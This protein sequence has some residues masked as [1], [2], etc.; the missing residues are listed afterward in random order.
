MDSYNQGY[1]VGV[2]HGKTKIGTATIGTD[3][4][5]VFRD[6]N[7]GEGDISAAQSAGFYALAYDIGGDGP[8]GLAGKTVISFRGTDTSLDHSTGWSV[9]AGNI[10]DWTQAPLA[11]EFYTAATGQ[12]YRDGEARDVLLTGHS[13]GGGL[14]GFVS[15]LS[16]TEGVGFDHM[17]F[18]AAALMQVYQDSFLELGESVDLS[19]DVIA[20]KIIDFAYD[21]DSR[22]TLPSPNFRGVSVQNEIL[23]SLRDGSLPMIGVFL[24]DVLGPAIRFADFFGFADNFATQNLVDFLIAA[25]D[26]PDTDLTEFAIASTILTSSLELT[27]NNE[28]RVIPQ[29]VFTGFSEFADRANLVHSAQLMV[30]LEYAHFL[31]GA[32]LEKEK[33]REI[34]EP[35]LMSFFSDDIGKQA[36]F[37][38]FPG[39]AASPTEGEGSSASAMGRAIA[40]SALDGSE[41][42]VFGNTGI[43][44]L[45]DDANELGAVV[46]SGAL[47]DVM[48]AGLAELI[49]QFAGQMALQEVNYLALQENAETDLEPQEGILS[50]IR[51]G[52]QVVKTEGVDDFAGAQ[53]LAVDM[54]RELW[55]VEGRDADRRGDPDRELKFPGV[56]TLITDLFKAL[57]G[58]D[59][60]R[61][62][63]QELERP[64]LDLQELITEWYGDLAEAG[65][66]LDDTPNLLDIIVD[67]FIIPLDADAESLEYD[68]AFLDGVREGDP[69]GRHVSLALNAF[70]ADTLVGSNHE[71]ILFLRDNETASGGLGSDLV[72]GSSSEEGR[73]RILDNIGGSL[74]QGGTPDGEPENYFD[75]VYV[76]VRQKLNWVETF[77]NW[78]QEE[79]EGTVL[80][81]SALEDIADPETLGKH[82]FELLRLETRDLKQN[83]APIIE[84][85][86]RDRNADRVSHDKLIN[87]ERVLLTQ[88]SDRAEI[89]DSWLQAPVVLDFNGF[90][91]GEVTSADY[92]ELSFQELSAGIDMV[93]GAIRSTERGEGAERP[94]SIISDLMPVAW[95]PL[96][97][98]GFNPFAKEEPLKFSGAEKIEGT[99]YA[100]NLILGEVS[101]L[102]T[103]FGGWNDN[104][105]PMRFGEINAG[106]GEDN[107]FVYNPQYVENGDRL[108]PE[109]GAIGDQETTAGA[110][111]Y[112]RIDGGEGNDWIS[113]IGGE[114]AV[115]IGGP[116]RDWIY[117]TSKGGVI[118]GDTYT[119][120]A[121]FL[122]D[123][124]EL[125]EDEVD[126]T[127][128]ENSDKIWYY[129]GTTMMDP[130]ESDYLA[131]RGVPLVGGTAGLPLWFSLSVGGAFAGDLQMIGDGGYNGIYFD[132]FI[133][134][135][136]YSHH[137]EDERLLVTNMFSWAL[138]KFPIF[139]GFPKA[140]EIPGVDGEPM[141]VGAMVFENYDTFAG[142]L[143]GW[144]LNV[145]GDLSMSFKQPNA[146]IFAA[147][148]VLSNVLGTTTV[149]WVASAGL[150][151]LPMLDLLFTTYNTALKM[152]KNARW[153]KH[154]DPLIIDLDGDGIETVSRD[155]SGVF[156]DMDGDFFRE[157]TGWV[158]PDDG[159]LTYDKNGN[160]RID[161]I[162]ELFGNVGL[163]GIEELASYDLNGDGVIDAA[164]AIYAEL[165][166]W[167]DLDQDGETDAGEL[168]SL[169]ERGI[170]SIELTRNELGVTTPQGTILDAYIRVHFQD[171]FVTTA[172]DSVLEL[173]HMLTEFAGESGT[174]AWLRGG[175]T[176]NMRGV[177]NV[178]DLSIAMSNDFELAE[179]VARDAPLM[180]VP[181]LQVLREQ[182]SEALSVWGMVLERSRELTP[183][184]TR[185]DA[186]GTALVDRGV[187]VED[188]TGG[189][190]TLAS[191]ADI[192]DA[193]GAIIARPTLQ[194]VMAQAAGANESWALEQ[195]FSASSRAAP[196]EHREN[197]PY[198]AQIVDGRVVVHDYGVQGADGV[199]SLA[200]G[201]DVLAQDGSVIA[202]PTVADILAQGAAK[203]LEWR[204]EDLQHN[205]LAELDVEAIGVYVIDE[206]AVDY[207][208]QVTDRDGSFHVWARN[209][210]RALELQHKNG[211]A[212]DFNLRN[213]EVDFETLDEVGSSDDSRY[214][215]ELLTPGQFNFAV[216]T[217]VGLEFRP[218]MLTAFVDS[219]T[220]II[221]YSVD[222]SGEISLSQDIYESGIKALLPLVDLM[223]DVWV[224]TSRG[225][226]VRM[227][228]QGGLEEFA[229]DLDF[230][231]D[232]NKFS[233][234]TDRELAPMFEAI[235]EAAPEGYEPALNYLTGW[236]QIMSFVLA[237]YV[238]DG[239]GN[240][241]GAAV[242]VDQKFVMQMLLPA[243]EQVGI[244]MDLRAVLNTFRI[245]ET[246]LIDHDGD[247]TEVTGTNRGD[248]IYLSGGDQLYRG[249]GGA[250]TYFV[251]ADFGNDTIESVGFTADDELRFSYVSSEDVVARREGT[252]LIL[253]A[254]GQDGTLT[255]KDHFLGEANAFVGQK[256]QTKEMSA[257]VFSDGVVWDPFLIAMAV[258]DPR[259]TDDVIVGSPG[260]DVLIG[261][262][263]NDVMIGG[264]GDDIYVYRVG[265]GV[266]VI[267]EREN[268][269][270][271]T[272]WLKGGFDNLV[273]IGDIGADDVRLSR[274]GEST[275]LVIQTLDA[276]GNPD[277]GQVT[278]EEHF[279]G[280][281]L[282][283]DGFIGMFDQATGSNLNNEFK[284]DYVGPSIVEQIT[285]ED[286]SSLDFEDMAKRVIENARTDGE[287]AIYG[288]ISA[289]TL[290]GGA[291]DDLLTARGGGDTYIYGLG[292]GLD[293]IHD[294]DVDSL[295]LFGAPDDHLVFTDDLRWT[296]FEYEREGP[297]DT[298][299]MRL[300]GTDDG[301]ILKDFLEYSL[302]TFMW[303][304]RIE[305]FT[306]GDGTVWS[307]TKLL[308]AFVDAASTDGDD[309][310]YGFL[311]ADRLDGGLG[312]DAL[313]G[314]GGNDS[315]V[316]G[317]NYG[318]DNVLDSGGNDRLLMEGIALEDV[319]ILREGLD[320][321][322]EVKA[323]GE[324]VRLENQYLRDNKQ[325]HAVEQFEFEAGD[326]QPGEK[327]IISYRDLNPE[328]V[329][330][331]GTSASETLYG[332]DFSEILDGRGGD[333]TLIGGSDGDTY[334][335]DVGYGAD[336]IVDTQ[337]RTVWEGRQGREVETDDRVVFGDDITTANV[338]FS[339]DG[340]DLLISVQDRTDT[341]RI[342]DQFRNIT[343][344][345]EL[346]EFKDGTIW[347]ISDIEELLQ[348]VGGNR[349]DNEIIGLPDQENV[350]DGRQGD[351]TLIGGNLGDTYAFGAGYD[352]DTIIERPQSNNGAID[353][354]VF[355]S[356]VDVEALVL[357][358]NGD[359]LIIDIGNATDVLTIQG[360]LG[361]NAVEEFHFAGGL[362]LTLDDLKGRMVTG[363]EGNDLL[364]GFDDRDD[365]LDSGAGTD[366]MRGGLGNDTYRFGFGDGLDA[367]SDT[368]GID[369]IAFGNGV[370]RA[371]V[372]FEELNGDLIIRVGEEGD[373]LAVLGG[374][375]S[376]SARWVESF[377]FAD[378]TE[379]SNEALRAELLQA[380]FDAFD[381]RVD[382]RESDA[383]SDIAPGRGADDVIM[384]ADTQFVFRKG[385]GMDTVRVA[386]APVAAAITLDFVPGE[387][388][389]RREGPTSSDLILA[390]PETGDQILLKGVLQATGWP[391][392]RFNNGIEWE[393]PDLL[394][395]YVDAQASERDD[396]ITG[397]RL[398]ETMMGGLGDDD[399]QGGAG[400]DTYIFRRGDGQ[401]VIADSAGSVDVLEI[402]GY[403]PSDITVTRISPEREEVVLSFIGTPDRI[404]LRYDGDQGVDTV[405]FSDG[406]SW[407]KAELFA[408]SIGQATPFD[409][410][411]VGSELA[412]TL[413]GLEGDDRLE[414][415]EGDDLYVVAFGHGH[416]TIIETGSGGTADR[417]LLSEALPGQ[418]TLSRS[419]DAL[420]IALPGG[421]S[422]TLANQYA[423]DS[424]RIETIQFSDATEW[425][426]AAINARLEADTKFSGGT[427]IGTRAHEDYVHQRGDGS[428]SILD[429]DSDYR[430]SER[431][432]TL[433][434]T[435]VASDEVTVE[436]D[437]NDA[438]IR[439]DNGELVRIVDQFRLPGGDS[440]YAIETIS[441]SDGV[442]YDLIALAS[443]AVN[444]EK[445]TGVASGTFVFEAYEY[446]RGDGPLVIQDYDNDY[447][448]SYRTDSLTFTDI[449]SDEVT[450]ESD[451]DDA[452]IRVGN[453]DVVRIVDQFRL[454][455][456]DSDY[457]IETIS[458]SDGVSYDLLALASRA[459]N[460]EKASGVASGTFV[461]ETYTHR[462]GDGSYT[463]TDYDNDYRA[464][465]RADKLVFADAPLADVE[466]A[467]LGNDLIF[468]LTNGEE[469]RIH[470]GVEQNYAIETVE[471]VDGETRTFTELAASAPLAGG[472]GDDV[473]TGFSGNDLLEGRGGNDTLD[474]G[475]G[476]DTILGGDGDDLIIGN[477]GSGD[478]YF[479]GDG[480]DTLDFT[481]YSADVTL[482][483]LT[484]EAIFPSGNVHTIAEF[485]NLIAG[486]GNNLIIGSDAGNDLFASGGNATIHGGDGNDT[487]RAGSGDDQMFGGA[488]DDLLMGSF[489]SDAFD[490]GE[491]ID[492]LDLSCQS[493]DFTVDLA[494]G[495]I[496]FPEGTVESVAN[497]EAV[498]AGSGDNLLRGDSGD[499]TLI[500]GSG[501][502]TLDGGAGADVF[503]IEGLSDHETVV[504]RGNAGEIDRVE[505][506]DALPG[507]AMLFQVG[508]DLEVRLIRGGTVTIKNQFS[509]DP[510]DQ[511][512]I[513]AFA[514]GTE[515]DAARIEAVT[516][517]GY[518]T[519]TGKI[520]G[521]QAADDYTHTR[522]DGFYTI[523][524]SA[525]I[526]RSELE[527]FRTELEPGG[528]IPAY[529]TDRYDLPPFYENAETLFR[530]DGNDLRVYLTIENLL[531]DIVTI[532]EYFRP[533]AEVSVDEISIMDAGEPLVLDGSAIAARVAADADKVIPPNYPQGD[534]FPFDQPAEIFYLTLDLVLDE[535]DF[536]LT[537]GADMVFDQFIQDVIVST[538]GRF[539]VFDNLVKPDG[540]L[541]IDTF[542]IDGMSL[543]QEE[544]ILLAGLETGAAPLPGDEPVAGD[545]TLTF[546]DAN[547]DELAFSIINGNDLR[548][549]LDNGEEI[550]ITDQF[551]DISP[552]PLERI[553]FADGTVLDEVGIRTRVFDDMKSSGAVT[554]T[555]SADLFLHRLGDGSY[556]IRKYDVQQ[557]TDRLEFTDVNAADVQ[558]AHVGAD[559]A[560]TLPNGETV[561]ILQHFDADFDY[562]MEEISFADGVVLNEKALR[563]RVVADMKATGAVVGSHYEET[564]YH[565]LGDG[566]YTITNYDPWDQTD[567]LE[568]TD[569]NAADVQMAH[570]GADLVITLPNGETVTIL[571]HFDA[572]F[573][574][575]MEEIS[576]A[577][578]VVLSEKALRDRVV[579]DMK[580]TGAVVGSHYE[581]T[582]YH[583][584]GD[585]SYTIT[586]YDPWDQTD[587]LEFTDVNAADV[588]MAHVGADLVI[589]LPNGETVTILQHFDA[590]LDYRMEEV[591]FADGVVLSDKALSDRVV[592]DMK[593]TGA[594][595]GSYS[596]E[597]FF[598]ALGDGSY[599]IY[600]WDDNDRTDRLEF[601][602]VNADE[603]ALAV[604]DD[605]LII[606]L[607]NG[608]S[609]TLLRQFDNQ[610]RYHL[611]EVAFAD[612]LVLNGRAL[613]ERAV[614]DMKATGMVQGTAYDEDFYHTQGD[615]SY[616]I[617]DYD[618]HNDSTDR[619]FLTDTTPDQLTLSQD[620]D[621]LVLTLV[622]GEEIRLVNYL[623]SDPAWTITGIVFADGTSWD[624]AAAT[625]QLEI[626][627]IVQI[628]GTDGADN[629]TGTDE[630]DRID[631]GPGDD[632]LS[633]GLGDDIYVFARGDGRD[634]IA[635]AG[636]GTDAI[637]ISGYA[638]GDL[639]FT[640]DGRDGADLLIRFA[641]TQDEIRI[642]NGTQSGA[643]RI[644]EIRFSE[645][646]D[647]LVVQAI[648][649]QLLTGQA[650]DH[651][652]L[653]E[654]NA[655]ANV[656]EAGRGN[657]VIDGRGGNDRYVYR[658]GDGDDRISDSGGDAA[659]VLEL[660]DLTPGQVR[661]VLRAGQD[662]SDLVLYF[663]QERDRVVLAGALDEDNGGVDRIEFADGTVW[664]REDMR[665][666]VL[667]HTVT[668][669][670]DLMRGFA[671]DD[672]FAASAGDDTMIGEAGA[673]T[674]LVTRGAGDDR[675]SETHAG[676]DIDRVILAD[677]VS[678]EAS[679][680]RLFKGSDTVLISFAT[681]DQTLTVENALSE[682]GEGIEEYVFS[683][684]VVWSK[685]DLL[686][687]TENTAP[688]AQDDGYYTSVSG[689]DHIIRAA[690]LLAND[691]DPD[692]NPI[693]L[694][695]VDGGPDGYAEINAEGNIVY[696]SAEGFTG[697]TQMRYTIS[698]GQNG[699]ATAAVD[700]RVR[701]VAEARSDD[702]F[703]VAE[704]GVLTIRTERLLS[705]DLDGDRMIVGQVFGAQN[706]IVSLSSAGEITFTP[707]ADFNGTAQFTYA[708]NTPE[709]G[710]AEAD[711]FIDVT[712]VNDA[713]VAVNDGTY[714]TLENRPFL[715]A[716]SDLLSNDRD[717]DGDRLSIA[718][719]AGNADVSVRLTD[720]GFVEVTPT[721]YFFGN[722]HF[723]YTLDDGQGLTDQGRVSLYVEP[724]NNPPEPQPDTL[725]MDEDH[726]LLVSTADLMA[727]D[728][729]YDGDPLVVT[730][731][732][733]AFGGTV[734][735]LENQTVEFRAWS[736]FNGEGY[737]DYT[738]DD[739]QGHT[740]TA[741]VTVNVA[742]VNDAP[743]AVADGPSDLAY[744]SGLEDNAIDISIADLLA[745][746]S[747]VEG[748]A[749]TFVS[750]SEDING[751]VTQVDA[752]TLRFT[753]DPDFWG[754]ASF[755]YLIRDAEGLTDAARVSMW[756]ENVGDGPPVA[757]NDVVYV[758]EDVETVIPVADLLAND[759]DIDR[760]V[761]EIISVRGL[762]RINGTLRFNEDGDIVF[763]PDLNSER[764]TG[765]TYTVTDNADGT[766]T[767]LVDIVM[768]PV[769]D[770]PEVVDDATPLAGFDTPWV[771]RIADI[772][773]NDFDI[774]IDDEIAFRAV[775]NVSSGTAEL[776]GDDFIVVRN[777]DGFSGGITM[778]YSIEDLDAAFDTGF[779]AGGVAET[780]D[781]TQTGSERRDLLIGNDLDETISGFAG[782][783]DMYLHGG[784]NV[785]FGGDGDDLI[786]SEGGA[787]LIDGGAGDDTILAG[788]GDDTIIGG[789]GGDEIDGGDGW[790]LVDFAGSNI[791]VRAGLDTRIGQG[792]HAQG[793]LY[794]NI[795]ALAGSDYNDTL[796]GDG[797]DNILEGR[798]G[799]D[800]LAGNGGADTLSG[801][802]GDDTLTG[803]AGADL[804][805]GG[806]G[807]DTADL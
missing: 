199:W 473:I 672:I 271:Y 159:F 763:T 196:L 704:D 791:G 98:T 386:Q 283:L 354:V 616:A 331:I 425:D 383:L 330:V 744:L 44:A 470:R 1:G 55:L 260:T 337:K 7:A 555:N 780:Y 68:D 530:Q 35:L 597:T 100:D 582:F 293:V 618:R 789:D 802:A 483:L 220:G 173:N 773:G 325:G 648:L 651:D 695:A 248:Y 348:I 592:A 513:L 645:S 230:D 740:G 369:R 546:T 406:T 175:D 724:V 263:G 191:G 535:F 450:V 203:G 343:D 733:N 431:T 482:N 157:S 74:A 415:G 438:V 143:F 801:G 430:P 315:Y 320:L 806:A 224:T 589:T 349:G 559:L 251:G 545:D 741:R 334:L 180:T 324:R 713:P 234:A 314:L 547:A 267:R 574:Y 401:D 461:F 328:D 249:G 92:D 22:P 634:V 103:L 595:I 766:D 604:S 76:G 786:L 664:T 500:G 624:K 122:N 280:M 6:P 655:A 578:G 256:Q 531:T 188:A 60:L 494:L 310:I 355:G 668:D 743:D 463:I 732:G 88:R 434:F 549:T 563:D 708:A 796:S 395:A 233:G 174:A 465:V 326:G 544:F 707:D 642:L 152:G 454:P 685:A 80:E 676:N 229:R 533:D 778:E 344:G 498:I 421:G 608:E 155:A 202:A 585:G 703:S 215:V 554:G 771:I 345:V 287:D 387:I 105:T 316:Y 475:T 484:G 238:V 720:D 566:S 457:A 514:D 25:D 613:R 198:L 65:V 322:F 489:G 623:S 347:H 579:A 490:G 140:D 186:D 101:P 800:R 342:R 37:E 807:S 363:T 673:D 539:Y 637:E 779:V 86:I 31:S 709:G 72:F 512:E 11:L 357:R 300:E 712:P 304:N 257:I 296:D 40:Y 126:Q 776:Y 505:L 346:F 268:G 5:R 658:D 519:E 654:G 393:L 734:R 729:E 16:G 605:D 232:S 323:T 601:T 262:R 222:G 288:F 721:D 259:E 28:Q 219:D 148:K 435:D 167:Q 646:G 156:F 352:F 599:T 33:W 389:V 596:E 739:G 480:I 341:L 459:V 261:D 474:G 384:G 453:G 276:D 164:D 710:R 422:V 205:P 117:N 266:D 221:D 39:T 805:D 715:I 711:V 630:R 600:N 510:L 110:Q 769:N 472:A 208:V 127:A 418:V 627:R 659:D 765:F 445:A 647:V 440:D 93:N 194:D 746:D 629:L 32:D 119:T 265:D 254:E 493:N 62:I 449:A 59:N 670:A 749:L 297:S 754:D 506:R 593:A 738:V 799:N 149:G 91:E 402:Y 405:R 41:G 217:A 46:G 718:A 396:V 109:Q 548:I 424:G 187:Y 649:D 573:D 370:T 687:A 223:L 575:R 247:A 138:D 390:A 572:D 458:F 226:A 236:N 351:D 790:D 452:V 144:N 538:S 329:D 520:G 298:L 619:L 502:D 675:I 366:E 13:L 587:R 501:N 81:Y 10:D 27:L 798:G 166:I 327:E 762:D 73:A 372:R 408:M 706:G 689:Q 116:G 662:G 397:G 197:A 797:A 201:A 30:L 382:A 635:D 753:P 380:G 131:L 161:D 526:G 97:L 602:D 607:A 38:G 19:P 141:P 177:G 426:I 663:E 656:I 478:M 471:F 319:T 338:I 804:L 207:T 442:S 794:N 318:N 701:P 336:V 246:L 783:D 524:E 577:D 448:A 558:M 52:E 107:I 750:W 291:G 2:E 674:Y 69:D 511:I 26:L 723:D 278:I 507:Q 75:D 360:G 275:D 356:A 216:S 170:V 367:I 441:F 467:R 50:F 722:A 640:R 135:I 529:T 403:L 446:S 212:R 305:T 782:D 491:G 66:D 564:F 20:Q 714:Q 58:V 569:V 767:G 108:S 23:E 183:V 660:P 8:E 237:D 759:T 541:S 552:V 190:W 209:L 628:D 728:I 240:I 43:R 580:A 456:G 436:S 504:D 464:S 145:V 277:G 128:Y 532:P 594:V 47:D 292:Y 67:K 193:D 626:D 556:T 609:V 213:F 371:F 419:G 497:I 581:E 633:G 411:L 443:R 557:R 85:D 620:G 168:S 717:I 615:G 413:N 90:A 433:T 184:L 665:A 12:S 774:D 132:Q 106:A 284:F 423:S 576:F 42:L 51:D 492:T 669:G 206:E 719:V 250:D 317:L 409:D 612:G 437:G 481:Y 311:T 160:G 61:G 365:V 700:I 169:E 147:L 87:I 235:F 211:D 124:G 429:Y 447:R 407:S 255:I 621:S 376:D 455:G 416:D 350:L 71:D 269:A 136:V 82:G 306:F 537:P 243:Y 94:D 308:Q 225:F 17:T 460:D 84:I 752:D 584:L 725:A 137:P 466:V 95:L 171:G 273:F 270:V 793:D 49:V 691:F 761:L 3:S 583:A 385:D 468:R 21:P 286:G 121:K 420:I 681:S 479:G 560:I 570:V 781:A 111:L 737:F 414:G 551:R 96:L 239:S 469:V 553:I 427:I 333:D 56:T 129:S 99:A 45:F 410:T 398:D 742:P 176:I 509:G 561:T 241:G 686:A 536:G 79:H 162:D 439:V 185:T 134:W 158:A 133:P 112:M 684:G 758:Y 523:S 784:D 641:D 671:E 172:Y 598:H 755:Y 309:V 693:T 242:G 692:G 227:A 705:N 522:G 192:L 622:N 57:N 417:L 428:Y 748:S 653:I 313:I 353:R 123:D 214:R 272:D 70:G 777:A 153:A 340:D 757:G 487:L 412:D 294:A 444:D 639:D 373:I 657:D 146:G 477:I 307:W 730:S 745:N 680:V 543:S 34:S 378:G 299:H 189:Y 24:S 89:R 281:R 756:F 525:E 631:A 154:E 785:A 542:R 178:V 120:T 508:Q 374:A 603:A 485:E 636:D 115:T 661:A 142:H 788:A 795:E 699:I 332:S 787:D 301:V 399:I 770:D 228:L 688:V 486:Q 245:D 302:T 379:L 83:A 768:I 200:S 182:A 258:A 29:D 244:D 289:D 625:A 130:G 125:I 102:V 78:W 362:V 666:E 586:N 643:D 388:D 747:D 9:G 139:S 321:I 113:V 679:A 290:D 803:G 696:R 252:D 683:D 764:S 63:W 15:A 285:F 534:L 694:I 590:D 518:K 644:E 104:D 731:L 77:L 565:A 726:I 588:Q 179:I 690:E 735:L 295:G 451:G 358:R 716:V 516:A 610:S 375:G 682:G 264:L 496:R 18:G 571:Q 400:N 14:A 218:E 751:T 476:D 698:D 195:V 727:N 702:G 359:D 792:G 165:S 550:T 364:I 736:D 772:V 638:P 678:S 606:T 368:G 667:G 528:G 650:S 567:R 540:T 339:K 392:I 274:A 617:T 231:V 515:W 591:A 568:F 361:A 279:G 404:T 204:L 381:N 432:D 775:E 53:L 4:E 503:V 517:A 677:F 181:D 48:V 760:D 282:N 562:R 652:D 151:L 527:P 614:S 697:P 335:F 611:E 163:S 312:D 377:V 54:A 499:N 118:Y 391:V 495:E 632:R 488:G 150:Q 303:T 210:D 462:Q 36:G 114:R 253:T 521:D 394:Q 64:D